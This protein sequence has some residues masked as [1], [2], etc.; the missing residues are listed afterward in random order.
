[1][2]ES[3]AT[4]VEMVNLHRKR[5]GVNIVLLRFDAAAEALAQAITTHADSEI[6]LQDPKLKDTAEISKWIHSHDNEDRNNFGLRLPQPL[7]DLASRIKFD[8]GIYQNNAN[9]DLPTLFNS[10]GPLSLHVDAAN[11]ISD[12]EI[13]PTERHG[14]GLYAKKDFKAGDLVMAEKA[15]ALPGYIENDRGSQCSL[16]SLGDGTATD[17]AGALLFKELV[18]KLDANP[19]HRK[20]FFDMDDGDYWAE[21]GWTVTDD[22]NYPVDV[23]VAKIS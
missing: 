10:I 14:R 21:K 9:Y 1:M 17:R 18:Q 2:T 5:C 13:R 23:Y 11:Y 3:S 6:S 19:S 12:T 22:S 16:Y 8:S 15:F 4:A 20:A 7:R